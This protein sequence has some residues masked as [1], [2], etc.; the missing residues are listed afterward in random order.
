MTLAVYRCCS[1]H[2]IFG[3]ARIRPGYRYRTRHDM[4]LLE[5]RCPHCG[6]LEVNEA[7]RQRCIAAST[8]G[9]SSARITTRCGLRSTRSSRRIHRVGSADERHHSPPSLERSWSNQSHTITAATFITSHTRATGRRTK[10]ATVPH[11]NAA[12]GKIGWS[13]GDGNT[14]AIDRQPTRQRTALRIAIEL[15]QPVVRVASIVTPGATSAA[16]FRSSPEYDASSD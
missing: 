3:N 2:A 16:T 8:A 5:V 10:A 14:P 1:G 7:I 12:S 15:S 13:I 11:A 6:S 4:S 9:G